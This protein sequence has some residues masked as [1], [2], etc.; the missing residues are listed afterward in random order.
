M[1]LYV[2]RHGETDY[3]VQGRYCG[4]LDAPLN[5]R[6]F[7]QAR[8]L[9]DSLASLEFDVIVSSPLLRARQTAEVI[10]KALSM[11]MA[12][13]DEFAEINMGVYEGLTKEEIAAK[14]P[15]LW[16]SLTKRPIDKA[17]DGGETQR[18]FDLRVAAGMEKL[19]AQYGENKVLLVCHG[20]VA[21][22][23]N[24]QMKGLSFEEMHT[25]V[26]G[27]CEVVKYYIN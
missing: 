4:S 18:E 8:E 10:C 21:R 24:R 2:T 23:I 25:F 7:E 16:A 6:G 22:V 9:A 1:I 17:P 11:P 26:L 5:A 13:I 12:V 15:Y 19:K 27:N 20:F 14:Y 3:N